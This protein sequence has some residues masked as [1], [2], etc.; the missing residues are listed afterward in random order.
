MIKIVTVPAALLCLTMPLSSFAVVAFS[1]GLADTTSAGRPNGVA[2]SDGLIAADDFSVT[3][4]TQLGWATFQAYEY[5]AASWSNMLDYRIALDSSGKPGSGA[6]TD[7][8]DSGVAVK[9]FAR[10]D[11]SGSGY[12]IG[13][14]SYD[15]VTHGFDLGGVGVTAGT[16]YWLVLDLGTTAPTSGPTRLLWAYNSEPSGVLVSNDSGTNWFNFPAGGTAFDIQ[17]PLPPTL[18]L[19]AVGLFGARVVRRRRASRQR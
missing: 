9:E 16:T 4:D 2:F 18:P 15:L 1:N 19:M 12:S 13:G 14:V 3:F 10:D 17:V 5:V 11:N 7:G 8:A 6:I